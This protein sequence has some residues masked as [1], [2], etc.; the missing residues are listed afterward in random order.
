[1]TDPYLQ[2]IWTDEV[3]GRH[4]YLV[5]DRLGRGGVAS[6]GLRMR[7]G[8]TLSEVADLARGM[9]LKEA[10]AYRPNGCYVP[11]GGAKGGID[12]N[13]QDPGAQ[14]ILTRY[15]R[16]MRPYLREV[17]A[18][19]EDLGL[20][21]DQIELAAVAVGL[22]TTIDAVL[23]LLDDADGAL[24]VLAAA[25]AVVDDGVDLDEL[26][27]GC[28]VAEAVLVVLERAGI[29]PMNA[30]AVIQGF[31]SIGGA[32]ARF[33]VRA[34]VRVVAVA[35]ADGVVANPE[36]LDVEALLRG[37]DK[38]GR[39][40][41]ATLRT[42][43]S[44]GPRDAWLDHD[45]DVLIPAAV[46]YCIGLDEV[47]RIRARF[48]VE[49]ANVPVTPEAEAALAARGVPVIPDFVANSAT[50]SWWWWTLFG[51]VEPDKD[52]SYDLIRL[53]MRELVTQL[54]DRAESGLSP[55]AAAVGMAEEKLAAIRKRSPL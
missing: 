53:V 24:A 46:S 44:S 34:G 28:G 4:G 38:F 55:R 41:R 8:V 37:R 43:D 25:F 54:L 45:C 13:P 19:G 9:S 39:I 33:L 10:V 7:D 11:V 2:V 51:D 50:N 16:A 42:A 27:G 14:E 40:D 52:S 22:R 30:R 29:E 5:V 17:W 49:G 32:T 12:C 48:V 36:G 15:L 21:Q 47:S 6:G 18:T 35:D 1:V 23:P 3:S 26:V 20:R 31:G